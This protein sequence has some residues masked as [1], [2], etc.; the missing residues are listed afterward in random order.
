MSFS[1][2]LSKLVEQHRPINTIYYEWF[3]NFEGKNLIFKPKFKSANFIEF[4]SLPEQIKVEMPD[5]VTVLPIPPWVRLMKHDK[6]ILNISISDTSDPYIYSIS[7]FK[8]EAV[9]AV[10]EFEIDINTNTNL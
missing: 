5:F 8:Y 1:V 7:M 9:E 3:L 10:K 2:D 6:R 4:S